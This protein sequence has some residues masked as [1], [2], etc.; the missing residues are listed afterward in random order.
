[1]RGE[2][3]LAGWAGLRIACTPSAQ[4]QFRQCR[5]GSAEHYCGGDGDII[6]AAS[7]HERQVDEPGNWRDQQ[8]Y[9]IGDAG[10][11]E[12]HRSDVWRG[13]ADAA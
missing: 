12:F 1:M 13:H 7:Q 11:P 2:C 5:Y 4:Q 10:K 6:S 9:D 3:L 8:L